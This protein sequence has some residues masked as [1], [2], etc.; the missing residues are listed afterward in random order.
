[1]PRCPS[2]SIQTTW[3]PAIVLSTRV[4]RELTKNF[5]RPRR[6][7]DCPQNSQRHAAQPALPAD[8]L[9]LVATQRADGYAALPAMTAPQHAQGVV[10]MLAAALRPQRGRPGHEAYVCGAQVELGG[11]S[12]RGTCG[13]RVWSAICLWRHTCSDD[14][15]CACTR[16]SGCDTSACRRTAQV[17]L[18]TL[19]LGAQT[20]AG[21][22]GGATSRCLCHTSSRCAS[23]HNTTKPLNVSSRSPR[24]GRLLLSRLLILSSGGSGALPL[25]WLCLQVP[26][27]YEA[28]GA[29]FGGT[30]IVPDIGGFPERAADTLMPAAWGHLASS[31]EALACLHRLACPPA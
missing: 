22:A 29:L 27:E 5:P 16:A 18:T 28:A 26:D 13:S 6:T 23:T 17:R 14:A 10:A 31:C 21:A 1:M 8:A 9:S 19:H 15:G 3:K 24:L 4:E 30:R 12:M 7:P 11:V 2:T 20:V 25:S